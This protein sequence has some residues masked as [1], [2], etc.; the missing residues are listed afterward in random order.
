[1][2]RTM[3][4]RRANVIRVRLHTRKLTRRPRTVPDNDTA[5]T[6]DLR[7]LALCVGSSLRTFGRPERRS[8]FPPFRLSRCWRAHSLNHCLPF[9]CCIM[10]S[11]S[12]FQYKQV[13]WRQWRHQD[14]GPGG[15]LL[16]FP[17]VPF[18]P[19]HF[20]FLPSHPLPSLRSRPLNPARG[21]GGAL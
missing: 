13:Y 6:P 15:T 14:L 2:I 9:S 4:T 10:H 18:P 7:E 3:Q 16:P 8:D 1:M 17:S 21:S 11:R 19:L 12:F 20:P 5:A